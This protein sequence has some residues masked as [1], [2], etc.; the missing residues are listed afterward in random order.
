MSSLSF[1]AYVDAS[2][3]VQITPYI[4]SDLSFNASSTNAVEAVNVPAYV[5]YFYQAVQSNYN[6]TTCPYK[7]GVTGLGSVMANKVT[8]VAQQG[9]EV[10]ALYKWYFDFDFGAAGIPDG[11]LVV[12]FPLHQQSNVPYSISDA[13][14][15]LASPS[16]NWAAAAN[17][18]EQIDNPFCPYAQFL[19]TV[20]GAESSGPYQNATGSVI[21]TIYRTS[22]VTRYDFIVTLATD[23]LPLKNC[24]DICVIPDGDCGC[25]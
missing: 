9:R 12:E 8:Q 24:D 3:A 13:S 1:S 5:Q 18:N 2:N 16:N 7:R 15:N 11:T 14:L 20:V 19:G 4:K 21:K 6:V 10:E 17:P 25:H 23:N 22:P